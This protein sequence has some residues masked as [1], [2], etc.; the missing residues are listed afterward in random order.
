MFTFSM[1]IQ[2][3]FQ[4]GCTTFTFLPAE[5]ENPGAL[6][7]HFMFSVFLLFLYF[8]NDSSADYLVVFY[9]D[10]NLYF[11]DD[12]MCVYWPLY[13]QEKFLMQRNVCEDRQKRRRVRVALNQ[14]AARATVQDALIAKLRHCFCCW[15]LEMLGLTLS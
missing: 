9:C 2:I 5:F 12:S 4:R 1:K 10:Y 3:D 8:L 14:G 15:Y 7:Q 6:H 13:S 11:P